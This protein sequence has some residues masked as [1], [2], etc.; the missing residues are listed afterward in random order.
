MAV[1]VAGGL[2][3]RAP[4][5]CGEHGGG[6]SGVR[7]PGVGA[8][9]PPHIT[10]TMHCSLAPA[11]PLFAGGACTAAA[12]AA[13]G[14]GGVRLVRARPFASR[15][16]LCS[17]GERRL[18]LSSGAWTAELCVRAGRAAPTTGTRAPPAP[19]D[20]RFSRSSVRPRAAAPLP[21]PE[22]DPPDSE[23]GHAGTHASPRLL[24]ASPRLATPHLASSRRAPP[25]S[26]ARQKSIGH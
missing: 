9:P 19:I 5:A 14:D 4:S 8:R 6:L 3:A 21:D 26:I 22:P 20:S 18:P 24:D 10:R 23:S 13:A 11:P 12:A 2:E 25:R 16:R 1:A 15:R 7:C 17:R